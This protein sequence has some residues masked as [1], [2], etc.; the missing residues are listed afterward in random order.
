LAVEKLGR[1]TIAVVVLIV[2]LIGV[3]V[4]AQSLGLVPTGP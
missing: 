4:A 2:I 3:T 1:L